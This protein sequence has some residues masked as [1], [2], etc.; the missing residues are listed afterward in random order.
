VSDALLCCAAA[1]GGGPPRI[2]MHAFWYSYM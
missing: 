1:G 2:Y